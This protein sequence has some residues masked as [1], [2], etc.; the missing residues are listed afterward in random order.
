MEEQLAL[1]LDNSILQINK[2]YDS[3]V[4][5]KYYKLFDEKKYIGSNFEMIYNDMKE[6]YSLDLNSLR[7]GHNVEEEQKVYKALVQSIIQTKDKKEK[8]KLIP[9]I[10][11]LDTQNILYD[12]LDS[13]DF[14]LDLSELKD[15][16]VNTV[17][18]SGININL[19]DIPKNHWER[20][21]YDKYI[22]GLKNLE[23]NKIY[24]FVEVYER[25]MGYRFDIYFDFLVFIT[26]RLFFNDL[27]E[28]INERKDT[29][30]IIYLTHNLSTEEILTLATHSHNILLKFEAIRK[31][32]YFKSNNQYSSNLLKN[33]QKLLQNII[34]DFSKENHLWQEFLKFY[35]VYPLR[36]PQLFKPLSEVVNLLKKD[37]IN[38]LIESIK[39]DQYISDDSRT[40]LNSCFLGIKNEDSQKYCLERLF[41]RWEK[42]IDTSDN[43]FL[44]I[45]LT[46]ILDMVIVYVREFLDKNVIIENV[47]E[48][49]YELDEINNKWFKDSSEK[50][51]Y[52]YKQMS[53]LFVYGFAFEKY[54]LN[55]LRNR[56][57]DI[58]I[59]CIELQIESHHDKKTTLQLFNEYIL[60]E[61]ILTD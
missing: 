46:D 57:K 48:V 59:N 21:S 10:V 5:E 61:D 9:L 40:A 6:V 36:N 44:G 55:E 8:I 58:C 27:I 52:F 47:E 3:E 42:F 31:S 24:N 30:G 19:D 50:T 16:F 29:F 15:Y 37:K 33:E 38:M 23:F 32:V 1:L 54:E 26:Y 14:F 43:Y 25:G 45:V 49:I 28:I 39:I 13:I 53:K 41:V 22:F 60:K 11:Y 20:E 56:V 18:E 7:C 35:L 51:N 2:I 17:R 12:Y 4:L 34:L